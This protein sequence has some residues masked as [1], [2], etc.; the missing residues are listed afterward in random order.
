M[1]RQEEDVRGEKATVPGAGQTRRKRDEGSV[2]EAN[3][4]GAFQRRVG[5]HNQLLTTVKHQNS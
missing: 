3:R 5:E 4:R 1:D 2:R